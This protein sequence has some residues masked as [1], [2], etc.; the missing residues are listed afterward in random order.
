MV[1]TFDLLLF[2]LSIIFLS[3]LVFFPDK[4]IV[5]EFQAMKGG[6]GPSVL[7]GSIL[8][9]KTVHSKVRCRTPLAEQNRSGWFLS[10]QLCSG[11]LCTMQAVT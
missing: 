7:F 8:L 3:A 4:K 9:L 5:N 2:I 11:I 10:T 1:V 6:G